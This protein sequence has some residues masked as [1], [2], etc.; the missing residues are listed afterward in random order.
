MFISFDIKLFTDSP[1][2]NHDIF[3]N[4]LAQKHGNESNNRLTD[5]I[6]SILRRDDTVNHITIGDRKGCWPW[7]GTEKNR[8]YLQKRI[9]F[10]F[11][12]PV[13]G[14]AG[15]R[16][17]L[18][19][20]FLFVFRASVRVTARAHSPSPPPAAILIRTT[21]SIQP[22][23][24]RCCVKRAAITPTL[25]VTTDKIRARF[26]PLWKNDTAESAR[27]IGFHECPTSGL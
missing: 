1:S 19:G 7:K 2:I 4:I 11:T 27:F 25:P 14:P 21:R 16:C 18:F 6:W 13:P 9:R 22:N 8:I 5:F 20:V 10:T 12:G 26:P 15:F 17:H 3:N 23:R 24:A